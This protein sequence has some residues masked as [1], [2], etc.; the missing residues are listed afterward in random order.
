MPF[1]V[2]LNNTNENHRSVLSPC[3]ARGT[4]HFQVHYVIPQSSP[5]TERGDLCIVVS[6]VFTQY[7]ICTEGMICEQSSDMN[8]PT[9]VGLLGKSRAGGDGEK[10]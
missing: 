9:F 5:N 4:N 10:G 2:D 7:D 8:H 3:E 6:C 1:S